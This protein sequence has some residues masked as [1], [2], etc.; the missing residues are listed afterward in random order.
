MKQKLF[1]IILL[2]LTALCLSIE[3]KAWGETTSYV[4]ENSGGTLNTIETGPSLP[5][6]GPGETLTYQ[7]NTNTFLGMQGLGG[8]YV[9]V[10]T[11]GGS[12]WSDLAHDD[13]S[14]TTTTKSHPIATNVTHI[15]FITKTGA[16]LKKNYSNVKV[17]R[18][19]GDMNSGSDTGYVAAARSTL[20]LITTTR[21]TTSR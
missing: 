8:I 4:L 14:T 9:Q 15:R 10:S 13:V 20:P 2:A 1:H 7:V 21:P 16:T 11:D 6:T 19:T 5:L 18:A 17:A 12:N 3:A